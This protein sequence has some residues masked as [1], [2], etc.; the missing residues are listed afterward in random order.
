M[1]YRDR[2][3][4]RDRDG[5]RDRNHDH[6]DHDH[7]VHDPKPPIPPDLPA[8]PHPQTTIV[9]AADSRSVASTEK[10]IVTTAAPAHPMMTANHL[11]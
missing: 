8:T 3:R 2:D 6:R 10:T 11:W 1:H 9:R 7:R 5:D 4:D